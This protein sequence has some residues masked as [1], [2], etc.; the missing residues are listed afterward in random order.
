VATSEFYE[1]ERA[2]YMTQ[3]R[4]VRSSIASIGEQ[5]NAI[6]GMADKVAADNL[7]QQLQAERAEALREL[8]RIN[9]DLRK[10]AL[11]E[12]ARAAKEREDRLLAERTAR[13]REASQLREQQV[14]DDAQRE[15]IAQQDRERTAE[16]AKQ[17]EIVKQQQE[18]ADRSKENNPVADAVAGGIDAVLQ[19]PEA[20][21]EVAH[22]AVKAV[23]ALL[24]AKQLAEQYAERKALEARQQ[25]ERENLEKN[26]ERQRENL[27]ESMRKAGKQQEDIDRELA[28][29]A[30]VHEQ[31]RQRLEAEQRAE[32]ERQAQR[33]VELQQERN[34]RAERNGLGV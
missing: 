14:R 10:L 16:I 7:A 2:R 29:Q 11:V 21:K 6:G 1:S 31:Q 18:V 22:S 17:A 3:A 23:D 24:E 32:L 30:E 15:V 34:D 26:I 9:E 33:Q 27:E 5:Q 25:Q 4:E 13:D 12:E 8:N 28:K 20:L 19:T